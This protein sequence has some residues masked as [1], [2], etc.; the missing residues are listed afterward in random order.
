[1]RRVKKY[2][3]KFTLILGTLI[4]LVPGAI[5]IGFLTYLQSE[6]INFE[7]II[8]YEVFVYS[9]LKALETDIKEDAKNYNI[10]VKIVRKTNNKSL[11]E[12]INDFLKNK[13]KNDIVEIK[14][15]YD[16]QKAMIIYRVETIDE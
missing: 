1:M 10:N 2:S 12:Q 8:A 3:K 4:L 16:H 6:Q 13:K 7:V 15:D 5:V 9:L 11:E 14:E